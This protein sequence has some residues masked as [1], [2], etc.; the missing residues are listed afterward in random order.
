MEQPGGQQ[1]FSG[2]L[3][4]DRGLVLRGISGQVNR[5]L[6]ACDVKQLVVCQR[7]GGEHSRAEQGRTCGCHSDE[8]GACPPDV[9]EPHGF[10]IHPVDQLTV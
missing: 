9:T 8:A 6:T 3:N 2:E 10:F 5:G 1:N 4:F 7:W